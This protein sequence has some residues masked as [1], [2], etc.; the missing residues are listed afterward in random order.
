MFL[1]PSITQPSLCKHYTYH[2]NL[3]ICTTQLYKNTKI[4]RRGKR[5][6]LDQFTKFK[7]DLTHNSPIPLEEKSKALGN[8]GKMISNLQSESLVIV[9][10][11]RSIKLVLLLKM[12][13]ASSLPSLSMC[14]M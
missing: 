7:N 2:N 11:A 4:K 1:N 13:E 3:L 9:Y 5:V 6:H 14:L 8:I 12:D 10:L